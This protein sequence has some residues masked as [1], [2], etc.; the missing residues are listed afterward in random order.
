AELGLERLARIAQHELVGVRAAARALLWSASDSL[1]ADPSILFLLVESEWADT[2]QFA[3]EWLRTRANIATLGLDGVMGLLDSNRTDVQD[4][5]AEL[6]G[7]HFGELPMAELVQRL[8]QHPHP[9]LR[10]FALELFL[11]HLPKGA[12]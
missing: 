3:F 6:V 10:G 12:A 9:H 2:R 5:G 4:A 7:K 1:A 8:A 11:H